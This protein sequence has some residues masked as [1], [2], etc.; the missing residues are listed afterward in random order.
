VVAFE[1]GVVSV[2]RNAAIQRICVVNGQS[3]GIALP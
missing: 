1:Q 2:P 3:E